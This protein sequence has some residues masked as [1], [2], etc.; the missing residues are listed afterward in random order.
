MEGHIIGA[1]KCPPEFITSLNNDEELVID[2][3]E[4]EDWTIR[5][6]TLLG[7]LY[8]YIEPDVAS[9]FVGYETSKDCEKS[10]WSNMNGVTHMLQ[11]HLSSYTL[12]YGDHL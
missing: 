10:V 2:K 11:N 4:Y 3:L 12:P 1:R 7:W 9:E 8:N 5:D 6:Q